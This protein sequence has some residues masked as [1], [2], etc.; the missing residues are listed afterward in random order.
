M[1]DKVIS[2]QEAASIVRDGNQVAMSSA[3]SW[4]PMAL[5][6]EIARKGAKDLEVVCRG[7]S[8]NVDFLVGTGQACS[9]ESCSLGFA[10]FARVAPNFDRLLK[11]GRVYANDNT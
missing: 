1:R 7:G 2:L 4:A 9:V 6:R 10:P 11:E 8:I 5:L 3:F